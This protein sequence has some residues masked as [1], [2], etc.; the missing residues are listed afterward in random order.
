[1]ITSLRHGPGEPTDPSRPRQHLTGA[2][3]RQRADHAGHLITITLQWMCP[4]CDGPRGEVFRTIS[5]D[6]SRRLSCDGWRN[7]YGHGDLYGAVRQ[8]AAG[9]VPVPG[10]PKR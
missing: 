9:G 7:P 4:V 3:L 5:Y 10:H 8:S 1:M 6:G 2:D